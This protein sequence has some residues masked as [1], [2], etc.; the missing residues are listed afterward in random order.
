MG[1]K[2]GRN[3][4]GKR[5]RLRCAVGE[6]QEASGGK[7]PRENSGGGMAWCMAR[8]WPPERR[9]R[10]RRREE[11]EGSGQARKAKEW[12]R[13]GVH[14]S[15]LLSSWAGLVNTGLE[16]RARLGSRKRGMGFA[17]AECCRAAY[18]CSWA[19]LREGTEI[20]HWAERWH[21]EPG[22]GQAVKSRVAKTTHNIP[23]FKYFYDL[24]IVRQ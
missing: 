13:R 15:R 3:F 4:W 11:R 5:W 16:C 21:T 9:R 7:C 2:L 14:G 18:V 10:R 24:N 22:P 23:R 17:L 1:K 12:R 20:G 19:V 8:P 6:N